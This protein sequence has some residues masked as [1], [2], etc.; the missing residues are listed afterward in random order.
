[1]LKINDVDVPLRK[2]DGYINLNRLC[3]AGGKQFA[4]WKINKTSK[5][6]IDALEKS[7]NILDGSLIKNKG[8][9]TWG[10]PQ[11]ATSVANWVS[12]KIGLQVAEWVKSLE[13]NGNQ[14]VK[15]TGSNG[16]FN[17]QLTLK[18]DC[19]ITI[20]MREDGYV[21]ATML[22]TAGGK[23]YSNWKQNQSSEDVIQALERSLG[24]P[25]DLIIQTIQ[26]GPNN[27]RGTYVHRRLALIIAQW[28]SAD[29]SVQVA[30][31]IEELLISGQVTLGK[32]KTS[33]QLDQMYKAKLDHLQQTITDTATENLALRRSYRHL[34][35]RHDKIRKKRN[36]HKFKKGN[37]VYIVTDQW[38]EK[39]YLK[40]GYT[41]NINSRLKT[42]RTSMPDCKIEFLVYLVKNKLLEDCLKSKY[43]DKLIQKNHE[44]LVDMTL[45]PLIDSIKELIKTLNLGVTYDDTLHLYNKPYTVETCT[46]PV[47]KE[48]VVNVTKE[49]VDVQQE[50]PPIFTCEECGKV[51]KLQGNLN[52]H[53]D[54]VHD[55][56]TN[57]KDNKKCP[58]CGKE[59]VNKGHRNRH[60]KSVH[61]KMAKVKCE[62]CSKEFST[63]DTL[64]QHL[65]N[66]HQKLGKSKC[67]Q[68]DKV[69]TTPGNLKKH[70]REIHERKSVVDCNVCDKTFTSKCN[71]VQHIN[72]VHERNEETECTICKKKILSKK[73]LEHHLNN[74]HKATA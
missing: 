73:G 70:I 59:F 63:R 32:E 35:E 41:D 27:L 18:D 28:I 7:L 24:I 49:P 30:S 58:V 44:Y 71:L 55:R 69:C 39:N 52:N 3:R 25:R 61:K 20:P 36:Y 6:T 19:I 12:P 66:V 5:Q 17:C 53:M 40:I 2:E 62:L 14:V 67:P 34:Q 26:K 65:K 72:L 43:S 47:S 45:Q 10:H 16:L 23:L 46:T 57:P 60:V 11:V 56:K 33:E 42:Y 21:N 9:G 15:Y 13:D 31:W 54:K 1:M 74:F 37:C 50:P 8:R 48:P 29:F 68:C 4:H 51:Y 38:R 64:V 22:C